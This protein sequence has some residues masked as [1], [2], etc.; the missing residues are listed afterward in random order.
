MSE[1]KKPND[2]SPCYLAVCPNHWGKGETPAKALEDTPT[3][4][5]SLDAFVLYKMPEGATGVHLDDFGAIR[6]T[7]GEGQD[8]DAQTTKVEIDAEIR[9]SVRHALDTAL[10]RAYSLAK[11]AGY[12]D[13]LEIIEQAQYHDD[14]MEEAG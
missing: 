13:V 7:T 6:W 12:E 4:S 3:A 8:P 11:I 10:S 2:P 9:A 5:Y 14:L 1:P